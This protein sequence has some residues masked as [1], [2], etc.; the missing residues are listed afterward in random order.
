[1][2][3]GAGRP[4]KVLHVIGGLGPGGAETLLYRMATR[5]SD[6]AHEVVC[7]GR[8]DWYSGPLEEHGIAVHHLKMEGPAAALA[9]AWR[10]RRLVRRSGAQVVQGW[11]YRSNLLAGLMAKGLGVPVVWGI[12]CSSLDPLGFAARLWV[13]ASGLVAGWVPA[14]TINCSGR[15]AELHS[16]LGFARS[17]GEVIYNG[18]DPA[19][20]FP[21]AE[22]RER[23]RRSLAAGD[24]TLLVGSIA[25][26]HPQK[27]IPNLLRAV[28][29]AG[30]QGVPVRCALIGH[31]LGEDNAELQGLIASEGLEGRVAALGRRED[32]ADL[33]RALDV[34]ILA[35]GGGEAFPN[36]VAETMLSG[37]PNIVTDVG[38]SAVIVGESG[39]VVPPR[40][41]PAIAAAIGEAWRLKSSDPAAWQERGEAARE[42]VATRFTFERMAAAYEAV[43]RSLAGAE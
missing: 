13:Y 6:I 20:F 31:G 3:A 16:R 22:R 21:D 24:D 4:L 5:P 35:S 39:W 36:A 34:H 12:H 10:L 17:P 27:D 43:W 25:R 28:R 8:P 41:A 40:D 23:G 38:D 33:A 14:F 7:L 37:T 26:W 42:R 11:M 19:S 32:I 29:L 18:Y 1:M 9:G 15:S 2:S 30:E